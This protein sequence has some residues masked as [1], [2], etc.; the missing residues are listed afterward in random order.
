MTCNTLPVPVAVGDEHISL[1]FS[2]GSYTYSLS[3]RHRGRASDKKSTWTVNTTIEVE[4][5]EES[6]QKS[7]ININNQ[8][9]WNIHSTYIGH[10][11]DGSNVKLARFDSRNATNNEWH[12]YPVDYSKDPNNRPSKKILNEWVKRSIITN[13]EMIKILRGKE[14]KA[15]L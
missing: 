6:M 15:L 9:S 3:N 4:L 7:Y 11:K 1:N 13:S 8:L 12:G 10:D 14:V 5:F 2:S